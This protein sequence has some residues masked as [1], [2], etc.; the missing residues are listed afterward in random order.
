MLVLVDILPAQTKNYEF[1]V[2]DTNIKVTSSLQNEFGQ[3]KI[4]PQ[5]Y[6]QQALKALSFFPEL[7]KVHTYKYISSI[8]FE[9]NVHQCVQKTNK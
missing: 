3:N 8:N 4:L 7:K 1:A 2:V 9:A 5:G 6:T